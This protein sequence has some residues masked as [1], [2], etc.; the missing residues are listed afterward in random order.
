MPKKK[1]HFLWLIFILNRLV[2]IRAVTKFKFIPLLGNLLD[3]L[4]LEYAFLFKFI[5]LI[6]S[7][8]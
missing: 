2:L 4:D 6:T 7:L 3:F 1:R 8:H 5:G